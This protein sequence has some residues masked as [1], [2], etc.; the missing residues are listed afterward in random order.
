[1]SLFDL[2]AAFAAATTNNE[3]RIWKMLAYVGRYGNQ[4][5][6]VLRQMPMREINLLA[7]ELGR[8]LEEENAPPKSSGAFV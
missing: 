4:P 8:I 2:N 7:Q 3:K 5:M 6:N 1:M